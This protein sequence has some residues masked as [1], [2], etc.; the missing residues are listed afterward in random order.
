MI[1]KNQDGRALW[2]LEKNPKLEKLLIYIHELEP[3]DFIETLGRF[4]WLGN[5]LP[6]VGGHSYELCGNTEWGIQLAHNLMFV[7]NLDRTVQE[8][9]KI[10]THWR[11]GSIPINKD[12]AFAYMIYSWPKR[13][14]GGKHK[15]KI[16]EVIWEELIPGEFDNEMV[17][18]LMR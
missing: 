18:D 1:K 9:D 8:H 10:Y 2:I 14:D 5:E 6:V 15:I 13:V 17:L 4:I 3:D 16:P 12:C 7:R 11:F